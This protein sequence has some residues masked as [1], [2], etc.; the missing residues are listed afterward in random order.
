MTGL[1]AL[2]V[3]GAVALTGLG[4]FLQRRFDRWFEAHIAETFDFGPMG[5]LDSATSAWRR[6]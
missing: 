3:A 4:M 1:A 6:L 2:A 5:V